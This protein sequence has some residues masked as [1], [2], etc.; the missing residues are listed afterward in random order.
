MSTVAADVSAGAPR[1]ISVAGNGTNSLSFVWPAGVELTPEAVFAA[2]D[3]TAAGGDVTATLTIQEQSG[4]IIIVKPQGSKVTAGGLGSASWGL[5][6]SDDVT[7]SGG[8][9]S[10]Q[11]QYSGNN[12]NINNGF[13]ANLTWNNINY[14]PAL[15]NLANPASP[16][17]VN[18][19]IYAVVI[20]IAPTANM[21]VGGGYVARL[22][23]DDGGLSATTIAN[24]RPATAAA[25]STRPQISLSATWFIPAGGII[26]VFVQNNDGAARGYQLT[27][28]DVV[29]IH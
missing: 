21:T 22:A 24:S 26:H 11:T 29:R 18:A 28:A 25:G 2:I 10:E 4:E 1:T 8:V 7:S 16:T 19:G 15:L 9:T 23:L 5:R 27:I 20:T 3:A 12:V 14:G 17:V 13:L 6:L